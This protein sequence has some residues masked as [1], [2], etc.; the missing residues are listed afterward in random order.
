MDISVSTFVLLGAYIMPLVIGFF[1]YL[2]MNKLHQQQVQKGSDLRHHIEQLKQQV[3]NL[4][5]CIEEQQSRTIV[6]AK[7]TTE[8]QQQLATLENQQ[9]EQQQ[10]DPDMRLYHRAAQMIKAGASLDE[11][12]TSCGVP[13]AEAQL[14]MNLH[15]A[16]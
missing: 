16:P 1:L 4:N 2:W 5:H 12:M 9:R 15:K 7:T 8:L 11:V 6:V 14:L 3:T 13:Y 10:Q